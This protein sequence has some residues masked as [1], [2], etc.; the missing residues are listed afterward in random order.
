MRM[1]QIG[2]WL[3]LL[4]GACLMVW[5]VLRRIY[6]WL[7]EPASARL[8][9]LAQRGNV[10]PDE[11]TA[12]LEEAGFKVLAGKHRIPLGV[13]IDDEPVMSTRLFF[14]YLVSKDDQYFLV[15][16]ERPRQPTEWTASGLRERYLVYAL[17]FPDC[18]GIV[19]ADPKQNQIRTV[20]FRVEDDD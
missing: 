16:L 8:R 2:D 18:E 6:R 7:Q 5:W 14:D 13:K 1:A 20:R 11:T 10:V 12:M 15:K 19:V 17:L 4:I 9:R 3:L